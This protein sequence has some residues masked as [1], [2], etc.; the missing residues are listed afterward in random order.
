M[1]EVVSISPSGDKR[2]TKVTVGDK[3]YD[4]PPK[5]SSAE[6]VAGL[7]SQDPDH[8]LSRLTACTFVKWEV[9][10][11][12]DEDEPELAIFLAEWFIPVDAVQELISGT[13]APY[14]DYAPGEDEDIVTESSP[15]GVRVKMLV[16]EYEGSI[17]DIQ[18]VVL[19]QDFKA[20]DTPAHGS[21]TLYLLEDLVNDFADTRDY[22][23]GEGGKYEEFTGPAGVPYFFLVYVHQD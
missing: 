9:E 2:V 16:M 5:L 20:M 13:F 15:E 4:V 18:V 21:S 3:I 23:E 10:G 8:P 22:A 6:F 19:P 14:F 1:S 17:D 12:E 11:R 7:T